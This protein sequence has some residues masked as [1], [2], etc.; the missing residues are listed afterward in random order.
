MTGPRPMASGPR[1]LH[2][3]G[4]PERRHRR[5]DD[6]RRVQPG[7]IIL[8][9]R[10]VMVDE[11]IGQAGILL[12]PSLRLLDAIHLATVFSLGSAVEAMVC[13]D[14]RLA[15]AATDAGSDVHFP[16]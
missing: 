5:R 10:R 8:L 13:Y 11:A 3:R 2:R 16:K 1:R 14:K 6:L 15:E 7:L 9:A 12:P 4:L